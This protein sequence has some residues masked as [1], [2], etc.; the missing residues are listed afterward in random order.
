MFDRCLYFNINVLT[1]AV[2]R[3]WEDSFQ[4]C[5]LSPA[6]AYIL[7][8]VLANPGQTQTAIA[9]ELQL[10]QSTVTRFVDALVHKRFVRR[11]SGADDK[12]QSAV[13]PTDKA[14]QL[15]ARLEETGQALYQR[16]Q[17]LIGPKKLISL[18]T[19]LRAAHAQIG[20][21]D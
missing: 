9:R 19:E 13:Y 17:Q 7:R 5:G 11:E 1:R 2:N 6:H 16:M 12:R 21:P 4:E 14:C 3:I 18:V 15:R 10:S 20:A 8:Y